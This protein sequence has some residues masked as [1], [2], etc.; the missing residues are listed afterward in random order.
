MSL[1]GTSGISDST[2]GHCH[3]LES[4]VASRC[5]PVT[6]EASFRPTFYLSCKSLY[7]SLFIIVIWNCGVFLSLEW[8]AG[9]RGEISAPHSTECSRVPTGSH[10][11]K[12][13]TESKG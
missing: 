7:S 5:C 9:M 4:V 10:R 12:A 3:R 8:L 6:A 2:Q 1:L 11:C 13:I